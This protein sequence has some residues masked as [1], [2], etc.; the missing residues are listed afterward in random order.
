MQLQRCRQSDKEV[1]RVR[2]EYPPL[3]QLYYAFPRGGIL[4]EGRQHRQ[5]ASSMEIGAYT[6]YM[7]LQGV[8][9]VP[10]STPELARIPNLIKIVYQVHLET[11]ILLSTI[12]DIKRYETLGFW[13]LSYQEE[14]RHLALADNYVK[15]DLWPIHLEMMN[16]FRD[17]ILNAV[18]AYLKMLVDKGDWSLDQWTFY[19]KDHEES[20]SPFGDVGRWSQVLKEPELTK[21]S[22][23][24]TRKF[25]EMF[26]KS[27]KTYAG[28]PGQVRYY[29][30]PRKAY[31]GVRARPADY[32]IIQQG[33]RT[34]DVLCQKWRDRKVGG[35]PGLSQ[36]EAGVYKR[37]EKK[38]ATKPLHD[39]IKEVVGCEVHFL[40]DE[41]MDIYDFFN[42]QPVI[43]CYDLKTAEKQTGLGI[44]GI[45]PFCCD[46]GHPDFEGSLSAE[47]YSGIGPTGPMNELEIAFL[48]RAAILQ[49]NLHPKWLA[50]YSDN[51]ALDCELPKLV[52]WDEDDAFCGYLVKDK[53]FG[54]ASLV[55]D[56]PKHR[57]V[58]KGNSQTQKQ[59]R[60]YI[61]RPLQAVILNNVATW[62][63]CERLIKYVLKTKEYAAA[64]E[65]DE[66]WTSS[67]VGEYISEHPELVTGF[68]DTFP[69]ET[70]YVK[71]NFVVQESDPIAVSD[72]QV[73]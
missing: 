47:S 69:K 26:S 42:N 70:K 63:S 60:Q 71:E 44:E 43:H 52:H 33:D 73:T 4:A 32:T 50:L 61:M 53:H 56:N 25:A 45:V 3:D 62:D 54:P 21:L 1:N 65:K 46:L 67:W 49:Y 35:I 30:D 19:L 2:I 64:K 28:R 68:M 12:G 10:F 37:K 34:V 72:L 14:L 29:I 16:D 7:N 5:G 9:A 15:S 48:L 24:K 31:P 41:A 57:L 8:R 13:I 40:A 66:L 17:K 23:D 58:F 27:W 59:Y 51:F 20:A 38:E 6:T 11:F 55:T 18:D 22:L 39:L 36:L